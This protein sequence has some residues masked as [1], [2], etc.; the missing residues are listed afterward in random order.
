MD[1][2][3]IAAL[4]AGGESIVA[5]IQ[6]LIAAKGEDAAA[7]VAD[8][9]AELAKMKAQLDPGGAVDQAFAKDDAALESAIDAAGD[10]SGASG[11]PVAAK[12]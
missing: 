5:L 10:G 2:V 11:A 8:L 7:A 3:T 12:P 6:K 9:Q 4:V 1:P